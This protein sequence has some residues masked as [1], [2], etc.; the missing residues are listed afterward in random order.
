MFYRV[1]NTHA[2][3][4]FDNVNTWRLY[5]YDTLVCEVNT[6]SMNILLSPAARYS[7][8]T[9]RHLVEFLK[10]FDVSYYAAKAVLTS[11][12]CNRVEKY[13]GYTIYVSK[14]PRFSFHATSQ[15]CML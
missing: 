2:K 4:F 1:R 9:I 8:T 6:S 7:R 13:N 12:D 5:S 14:D 11:P 3:V 10:K 15:I